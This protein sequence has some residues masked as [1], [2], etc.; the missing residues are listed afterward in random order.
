MVM[1]IYL[2]GMPSCHG[3]Q[4]LSCHQI[5]RCMS[6]SGSNADKHLRSPTFRP[7][8]WPVER[9][10]EGNGFFN[11]FQKSIRW[12]INHGDIEESL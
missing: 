7:F 3:T 9:S 6:L 11:M 8:D 4:I 1:V 2:G 12:T 5:H 10:M